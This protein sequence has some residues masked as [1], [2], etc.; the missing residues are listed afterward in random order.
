[1]NVTHRALSL[2]IRLRRSIG[3]SWLPFFGDTPH[4]FRDRRARLIFSVYRPKTRTQNSGIK[5]RTDKKIEPYTWETVLVGRNPQQKRE[6]VGGGR[7][8][9]VVVLAFMSWLFFAAWFYTPHRTTRANIV[10]AYNQH[11]TSMYIFF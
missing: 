1:M 11:R 2:E 5:R 4:P 8:F 10:E 6:V 3:S 7:G 9:P